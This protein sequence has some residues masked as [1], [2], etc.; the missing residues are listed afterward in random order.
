MHYKLRKYLIETARQ[1][2]KF[3]YYSEIVVDCDLRINLR[4]EHGRKQLTTLLGDVS[5]YENN[6]G[7]PLI[8]AMAIYKDSRRNDHGDGFYMVAEK[9]KK[10]SF[11]TLKYGLFGFTEAEACRRFW[12]AEE[13]YLKFR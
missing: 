7:R 3:A 4:S 11:K 1:K 12:Q 13:N 8:S 10:G 6:H 2:D 5:E 9:L